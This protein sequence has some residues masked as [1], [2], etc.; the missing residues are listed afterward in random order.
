MGLRQMLPW[1]RNNIFIIGL[2]S[3]LCVFVPGYAVFTMEYQTY[4]VDF[5][6]AQAAYSDITRHIFPTKGSIKSSK[7]EKFF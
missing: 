3:N 2:N 4:S 7:I 6:F 5:R 1:H